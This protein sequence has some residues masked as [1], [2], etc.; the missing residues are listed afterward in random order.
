MRGLSQHDRPRQLTTSP[1]RN[2]EQGQHRFPHRYHERTLSGV[3][4]TT[5]FCAAGP[6]L[7]CPR[8][9]AAGQ[10]WELADALGVRACASS[11]LSQVYAGWEER[12]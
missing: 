10:L 11:W 3:L 5:L 1:P 9:G 6:I 8:L 12:S 7:R 4:S 2:E